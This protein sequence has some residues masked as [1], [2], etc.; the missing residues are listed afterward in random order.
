MAPPETR[1][2]FTDDFI[3]QMEELGMMVEVGR[4]I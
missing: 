1:S 3:P 2:D 4:W